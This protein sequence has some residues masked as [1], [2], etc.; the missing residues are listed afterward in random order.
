MSDSVA[1]LHSNKKSANKYQKLDDVKSRKSGRVKLKNEGSESSEDETKS[2]HS[3]SSWFIYPMLIL[4][5][6]NFNLLEKY[7]INNF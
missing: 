1:D 7:N 4:I 5:D 6:S 2:I 3:D